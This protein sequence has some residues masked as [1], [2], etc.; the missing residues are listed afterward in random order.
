MSSSWCVQCSNLWLSDYE[1]DMWSTALWSF[2]NCYHISSYSFRPWIVSSLEYFPHIYVLWPLALCTV[3]F[4]FPSSKKNSF[5][6]NYMRKYGILKIQASFYGN[7]S[8]RI[9]NTYF[10]WNPY[11]KKD[12]TSMFNLFF[13]KDPKQDSWK[14]LW[15]NSID[16]RC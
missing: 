10:P 14:V 11:L 16:F 8:V 1:T 15:K 5:R 6:G 4:G 7:H 3:T 13:V 9:L 2:Y 12:G